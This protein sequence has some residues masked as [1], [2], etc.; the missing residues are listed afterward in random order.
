MKDTESHLGDSVRLGEENSPS[1]HG[2]NIAVRRGNNHLSHRMH[3]VYW[4]TQI[5]GAA[6]SG[7][8]LTRSNENLC[9]PCSI[10]QY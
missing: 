1:F 9:A 4:R 5:R 10:V 7:I 6:L 2:Q 3:S 8:S